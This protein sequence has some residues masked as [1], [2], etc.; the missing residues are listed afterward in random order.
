MQQYDGNIIFK[1]TLAFTLHHVTFNRPDILS[2]IKYEH[3]P[4]TVVFI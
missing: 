2:L 4:K 3:L 1:L